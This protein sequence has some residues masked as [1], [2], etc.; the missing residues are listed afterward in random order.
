MVLFWSGHGGLDG[1][2]FRLATPDTFAPIEQED[3]LGL[4]EISRDIGIARVSTWTLFLDA[5][6]AGSGFEDVVTAVNRQ[7]MGEASAL[8]GFGAMFS[9]APYEKARDSIF[10][11]TVID[12]LEKGPSSA[13]QEFAE[14]Q[15]GGGVFNPHNR[16]LSVSEVFEAV[17][18][19]YQADEARF[20]KASPPASVFGGSMSL[21]IFPNPQFRE[22]KPSRLMEDAYRA[23]ARRTD[24]DSHFFPKAIGIENL[25]TGWHFTGRVDVTRAILQW[26]QR[27]VSTPA[28]ALYVLAADGGTGKSALLGRLVALTDRA[29]RGKAKAQGWSEEAD[30]DDGT[31]PE[32]DRIDAA[33]N[34]RNLTAQATVDR[35][36]EILKIAKAD[37]VEDFVRLARGA[38]ARKDVRAPCIVLDALDEAEDPSAI[39]HRVVRPLASAGWK[40]LVATRPSAQSR[41]AS[42]LLAALG[43]AIV[44]RLDHDSQSRDDIYHYAYGRLVQDP[45]LVAVAKAAAHTI[46]ER[47]ENKFLYARM[48]ASS[49]LRSAADVTLANLDRF[50]AQNAAAALQKDIAELDAA[51]QQRFDRRDAGATAMFTALAWAQGDGVPI[52]DGIWA[53]MA[54]AVAGEHAPAAGFDETHFLWLLREAGRFIQEAGDGEQAVYRLFHKSL[55]EHFLNGRTPEQRAARDHEE[56]LAQAL[57]ERV[58]ASKDWQYTNPY[59]VRHMPAHLAARP[60]QRGLNNL[61]LNFDWIQA[62]LRHSGIQ[63]LLK[64]YEYCETAYP[65]T[66]RLHRTLSMVQH[67]LRH[68][69]EQL[70]PQL[71][72]RIVPGVPDI[73]PLLDGR[74]GANFGLPPPTQE[75]LNVTQRHML[76]APQL[77]IE[78]RGPSLIDRTLSLDALLERAKASIRG[79]M[80]VPELGGLAQAGA[81]I[82]VM[83]GH[84]NVVT[85]VAVSAD[86]NF[87]V[88]GSEDRTVRVW[89]AKTGTALCILAGHERGVTCVAASSDGR[90][91]VSGSEDKTVRVWDAKTG[92]AQRVLLGHEHGVFTVATSPDGKTI[93]SGSRDGTIRVWDLQT[94]AELNI[95]PKQYDVVFS[96]AVSPNGKTIVSCS[97]D[98]TVRI[99]D[100]QTGAALRVVPEH[101]DVVFSVAVSPDGKNIVTGSRDGAVRV[102][103]AQTGAA[104][105]ILLGHE[106][107]VSSV[108]VSPDGKT[109]V[110]GS[111]DRTVRVWD[112]QSGAALRALPGHGSVTSVAVSPDGTTIISGSADR[113]VQMWDAQTGTSLQPLSEHGHDVISVAM[114]PDGKII[115]SGSHDKTVRVWDAK[116]G[117]ARLTL[118]G[119]ESGVTS[120]ALSPD[121]KT[122]VSGSDDQ[123]VRVWDARSGAALHILPGHDRGVTSVAMNP[124]GT[125]IVSGSHDKT[126]RVWDA[127]TGAA[128]HVLTGHTDVVFSVAVSPNG[129]SI[130][131][132]SRDRTVRV[133]DAQ[134]GASLHI[135]PGHASVVLSVAVSPD[136]KNI[137]SGSVDQTVRVW[138]AHTGAALHVLPGHEDSVTGVAVTPDGKD[139]ASGSIDKSVCVWRVQ[140]GAA[141]AR[142]DLDGTVRGVAVAEINGTPALA[143]ASGRSVVRLFRRSDT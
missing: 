75:G 18:A 123:T 16:L 58:R 133:W 142:L 50:I 94:G 68:H 115:V 64:D 60:A 31:V 141:L 42:D 73:R 77:E 99:W 95:L 27:P 8:R 90:S 41:G 103:D 38:Y 100:A 122:I 137:V 130:V 129:K 78:H 22:G 14:R 126:V 109:I 112:A 4:D 85:S 66:A 120:L 6:H 25:E 47:A 131:S 53:A 121:G 17:P 45:Q 84:E 119:H 86:G 1:R 62:R 80:W 2:A 139:I 143:V 79:A 20:R 93:V 117:A 33:L 107:F 24:L 125:T 76:R 101:E 61:L 32:A 7:L 71:L 35:L 48:S 9:S 102:W 128:R 111:R 19:E 3:G 108:A 97:R 89:D 5:C 63:A 34:L 74:P 96:V 10:L 21:R 72:G 127:K 54:S 67:I 30:R 106:D 55:V 39:V 114:S 134:T 118:P 69:P 124:D 110:S 113:T 83:S 81:L 56:D 91:I 23:I 44:C 37:S 88:S 49:L 29:Y 138:D 70:I 136:G 135:L 140:T 104:L 87:V 28:D 15:G 12:V 43:D 132:G 92:A 82:R 11:N 116:T 57:V 40:V 98:R 46:A 59:L 65:A 26:M 13:A 51:F 105:H 52:R 36:A